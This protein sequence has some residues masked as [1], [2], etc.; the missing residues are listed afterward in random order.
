MEVVIGLFAG[1]YILC[2][3]LVAAVEG[4]AWGAVLGIAGVVMWW[5]FTR[6]FPDVY[7]GV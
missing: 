6:I 2:K 1:L 7:S 5:A 4:L 3:L